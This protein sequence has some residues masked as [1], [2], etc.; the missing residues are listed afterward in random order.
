MIA[1]KYLIREQNEALVLKTI[2]NYQPISRANIAN[3]SGL[4][5]ASVSSITSALIERQLIFESSIGDA[6]TSGGRKPINLSF[7]PQA[8]LALSVD[9]G[10][11]YVHG[12]LSYLNGHSIHQVKEKAPISTENVISATLNV[13]NKLTTLSLP[14]TTHGIV[15]ICL[16]IH[17]IVLDD[18]IQFTPSYDLDKINLKEELE[19]F[20]S[21]PIYLENEA[22]LAALGEYTFSKNS[23]DN[24]I[25]ISIH[26]GIG[27]G[28]I[29]KGELQTGSHGQAG[30]IGHSILYPNGHRCPCGNRGCLEKYASNKAIYELFTAET[31]I[32]N[33]DSDLITHELNNDNPVV[34]SIV[35]KKIWELSIG[36]NDLTMLYDPNLIIIN[37]SIFQKNP[38][39]IAVL[40]AEVPSRFAQHLTISNSELGEMATLYG[41]A[42][43]VISTFL[44]IENARLG[45]LD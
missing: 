15:G 21:Y 33:V 42:A 2:I 5:K 38:E 23:Q 27:A 45:I 18:Q 39:L 35:H 22:N 29:Q 37:S 9:I 44:G 30:E 26:S 28:I 19:K 36:V 14:K 12:M 4:N 24:M 32:Q 34:R 1:D 31:D 17:G 3:H 16:G 7:N 25:S 41:G 40:K 10:S 8:G 13:I 43:K 6:G 20:I 11:N